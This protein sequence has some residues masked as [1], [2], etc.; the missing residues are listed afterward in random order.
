MKIYIDPVV[1]LIITIPTHFPYEDTKE[2]PWTYD[3]TVYIHGQ[4]VQD[5]P[6]AS[7]EPAINIVGTWGV[8]RSRRIF[9]PVPSTNDNGGNACQDKGKQIESNQQEHD[10]TPKSTLI[11]EVEEILCIIKKSHYKVVE[12]LCQMPSKISMLSLLKC[13]EAHRDSLVKLMR[14]THVPQ[15][16]AVC[17]FEGV[18]HNISSSVSLGSSGDELSLEGRNHNKTLHI[19]IECVD[20]ILS[21]DL[22]D[23]VSFLNVLPKSSLS[24]LTI[25]G[26]V[27]NPSELIIRAFN[28][29]RRKAIREVDLPIKIWTTYVF[30]HFLCHGHLPNL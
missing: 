1:P 16:I 19:S 6:L 2:I 15:E 30:H 7:K 26:L 10:S 12:Q 11:S 8:T 25:E 20:T 22:V 27:I 14:T 13:F 28:D 3:S 18:V 5:E 24:K 9:A 21:R 4:K 23:V 17:Q 29:S